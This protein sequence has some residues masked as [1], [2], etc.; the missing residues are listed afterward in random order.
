MKRLFLALILIL[1]C[2]GCA[3]GQIIGGGMMVGAGSSGSA[4][5]SDSAQSVTC[6]DS[7]DGNPGAVTITP[8]AGLHRVDISLTV[9][10]S[11][12]CT[13]TMAETGAVEGTIVNIVNISAANTATF[14]TSAGVLTLKLGS[15]FVMAS[16]QSLVLQYKS[17]EWLELGRIGSISGTFGGFTASKGVESD[18]S[19]NLVSSTL[20]GIIKGTSGAFSAATAGTD[21]TTPSSTETFTNKTYDTSGTGNVF[22]QVKELI[23][24]TPKTCDETGALIDTTKTNA[25]FGLCKFSNSADK[26]GNYADYIA[27]VPFDIDTNVDLTLKSFSVGLGGADTNAHAYEISMCA[28]AASAA[29]N[30]TPSQAISVSVSADASGASGDVEYAASLPITLTDWR[31]NVTAGRFWKIRVARDGD[32]AGDGSTVDSYVLGFTISYGSSQ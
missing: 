10:D 27:T 21:Y 9:N 30:C 6:T 29:W 16:K 14:T 12:G 15:P 7:G 31:S 17:S 22:K 5:V 18:A 32:A 8:T 24:T 11:D 23:F 3:M 19:G 2:V 13:V 26:A 25:T 28:P 20:T 4:S 1:G